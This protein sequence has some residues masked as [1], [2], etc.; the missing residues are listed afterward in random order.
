ME[1]IQLTEKA[2]WVWAC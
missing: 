2:D 1:G